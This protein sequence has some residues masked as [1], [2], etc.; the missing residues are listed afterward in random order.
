MGFETTILRDL[1]GCSNHW[2]T[3]DS[4][5]S[6]GEMWVFDWNLENFYGSSQRPTFHPCSP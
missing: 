6:K 2:A 4:M 5:V 1:V 3:G